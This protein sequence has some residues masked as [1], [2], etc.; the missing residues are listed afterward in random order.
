MSNLQPHPA[1]LLFPLTTGSEFDEL[2]ESIRT[3]GLREPIVLFEGLI[4]DGRNRYR[5]CQE[6]GVQPRFR[7]WEGGGSPWQYVWDANRHRRHLTSSQ[8]AALAVE[9]EVQLAKEAKERQ[10]EQARRNQPQA[11]RQKVETLPPIEKSK[12]R[13]QAAAI[14][15]TNG[16]YVSDAKAVKE[17]DPE[18]FE[19]VKAG[20]ITMPQARKEVKRKQERQERQE[21]LATV[22]ESG[23][24]WRILDGDCLSLLPTIERGSVRLAFCDPPYNIGINYGEGAVEDRLPTARYLSRWRERFALIPPLLAEDGSF[25]L[26]VPDEYVEYFALMLTEIGL[27]RHQWLIW[28]ETFGVL[29]QRGFGR[30]HRHLLW[31][32]KDP[33]QLVFYE[34]AV[35][36]PSDRQ[37]RYND[38]RAQPSGKIWDSVWGINPRL[39]RVAGTFD[40]RISDFPTQLPVALLTPII[41]CASDPGDLILDPCAGSASTGEAAV[42]LGRQFVGIEASSGY[43]SFAR[44]RLAKVKSH[45]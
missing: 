6:A 41:E 28:Y 40:E 10:R 31:Y 29:Q 1:A 20:D 24:D 44:H 35:L 3:N 32:V 43:A 17:K 16:R 22:P 39:S 4:L 12:A 30:C 33:K 8:L 34:T 7:Q 36:R 15:G 19:K 23:P 5:A 42:R 45:G 37:S 27:H 25:W 18:L 9:L 13:D 38:A 21:K 14:A 11:D 2:R 26:L